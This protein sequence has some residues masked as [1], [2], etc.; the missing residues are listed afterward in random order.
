MKKRT[1]EII[2]HF[3]L[4]LPTSSTLLAMLLSATNRPTRNSQTQPVTISPLHTQEFT[5]FTPS[6]VIRHAPFIQHNQNLII[7]VFF[8]LLFVL[9]FLVLLIILAVCR[10]KL[11]RHLTAELQRQHS[12]HYYYH[13]RLR[14]PSIKP[15]DNHGVVG[16][17]DSL[18]EQLPSLSSDSEQ[19][20]LYN[21]KKCNNSN[22]P[23]VPPYPPSFR[24]H[25]CCH[26]AGR[27][28]HPSTTNPQEYQYVTNAPTITTGY[29]TPTSQQH[30]CAA[31]LVWANRLLYPT[32]NIYNHHD[33]PSELQHLQQSL[34]SNRQ[35]QTSTTTENNVMRYCNN[36]TLFV[37]P[38]NCQCAGHGQ[39]SDTY[40]YPHVHR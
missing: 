36:E 35:D 25:L 27:L 2:D 17:N 40:I 15:T 10:R 5:T 6:T 16:T 12:H 37:S 19:P 28:L 22:A 8:L 14:P 18:Y 30:Q 26:P 39:H 4:V 1:T 11:R 38:T 3:Y 20:F 33:C 23:V 9:L 34:F 7:I 31:I 29:S 24:H 32:Q 13:A 21:E